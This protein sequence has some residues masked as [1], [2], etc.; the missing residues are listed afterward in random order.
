MAENETYQL[1]YEYLVE[2]V[3]LLL[4]KRKLTERT[5]EAAYDFVFKSG[6][7]REEWDLLESITGWTET[8][9]PDELREN[10]E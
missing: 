5:H 1:D 4:S 6:W 2:K 3:K 8:D 7:A 9:I 10:D